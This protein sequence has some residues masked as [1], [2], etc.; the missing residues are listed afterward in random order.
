ME[1]KTDN[2]YIYLWEE[3]NTIYVGRTKNPKS[4]HYQ[5]K[6]RVAESTYQFS[7]EHHIEHPKMIIIEND[8]S[9]EEG[10]KREKYWI[11]YYINNSQYN[12]L[13]KS[14][15]GQTGRTPKYS[16]E[17]R[18]EHNRLSSKKYYEANRE[19][20]IKS[21]KEYRI[22]HLDII[23]ERKRLSYQEKTKEKRKYREIVR[24]ILALENEVKNEMYKEREILKKERCAMVNREKNKE[25]CK[26]YYQEHR[27]T[28]LKQ[29]KSS[30]Q[31]YYETNRD[32]ILKRQKEYNDKHKEEKKLYNKAYYQSRKEKI[33]NVN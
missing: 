29:I 3:F 20:R 5:H 30:Q 15:G 21:A 22:K 32:K 11:D 6:H 9:L 19:N 24:N 27:E 33:K 23:K 14:R 25:Y 26:K 2:I 1:K 7:S 18:K 4:R 31:N 17:E 8:L 10:T 16:D 28:M 13:N 12:V